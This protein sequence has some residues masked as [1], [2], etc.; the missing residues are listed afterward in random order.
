MVNE[1]VE[2]ILE[3]VNN[4]KSYLNKNDGKFV[5]NIGLHKPK[6]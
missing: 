4:Y 5:V 3:Y 6:K 1:G 2:I